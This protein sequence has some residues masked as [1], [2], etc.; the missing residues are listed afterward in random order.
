MGAAAEGGC[1]NTDGS[2]LLAWQG[3]PKLLK[4]SLTSTVTG[5]EMKWHGLEETGNESHTSISP[6]IRGFLLYHDRQSLFCGGATLGCLCRAFIAI[7]NLGGMGM[8]LPTGLPGGTYCDV[9]TGC[10]TDTGCSG[11]SVSVDGGGNAYIE[12]T[13]NAE[14]M[15]AIHVG[16]SQSYI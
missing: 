5:E 16:M 8:T 9:I 10:A 2:L 7:T 4:G 11:K 12:I 15:L 3:L 6:V 14:P 1:V 13:N